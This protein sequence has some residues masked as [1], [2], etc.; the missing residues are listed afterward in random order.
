MSVVT[1]DDV[2][3][4]YINKK[5]SSNSRGLEFSLSLKKIRQLLET[6]I[7]F[8]TGVLF[9]NTDAN[10][11]TFD[12]V[13]NSKGYTDSNTIVCTQRFNLLKKN[14]TVED[15]EFLYLGLQKHNK[16]LKQALKKQKEE[17]VSMPEF[18][19]KYFIS[20][21][22]KVK[23]IKGDI[24]TI[25]SGIVKITGKRFKIDDLIFKFFSPT[26]IKRVRIRRKEI[27]AEQPFTLPTDPI[28]GVC[29]IDIIN[30]KQW[31]MHKEMELTYLGYT[32]NVNGVVNLK[33]LDRIKKS[34]NIQNMGLK[35]FKKK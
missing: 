25:N 12:R 10:K 9:D 22:G 16:N 2:V 21:K 11:L 23:N 6:K 33:A 30:K 5:S 13:D 24:L 4:K 35:Q 17:W 7:C 34:P 27:L 14:L 19:D 28:E 1:D 29:L 15:I 20:N 31:M 3:N 32:V 26:H 18:D 8:F